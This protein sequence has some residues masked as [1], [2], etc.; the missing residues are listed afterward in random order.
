MISSNLEIQLCLPKVLRPS[1]ADV[2]VQV[3][4]L[5]FFKPFMTK[6]HPTRH[7][8]TI[9]VWWTQAVTILDLGSLA[10]MPLT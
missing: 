8:V 6:L 1:R 4:P 10:W 2:L 3:V 9:R 5:V 7:K